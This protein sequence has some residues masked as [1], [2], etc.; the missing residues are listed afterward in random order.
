MPASIG[1]QAHLCR[2]ELLIEIEAMAMFKTATKAAAQ[3]VS[4]AHPAPATG[5]KQL[6]PAEWGRVPGAANRPLGGQ[7]R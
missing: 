3:E 5:T 2:P 7:L 4:A 1:I 6:V